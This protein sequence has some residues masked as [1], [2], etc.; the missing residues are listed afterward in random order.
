MQNKPKVSVVVV[1]YNT[2]DLLRQCLISVLKK[3]KDINYSTYV[4]DNGSTDDSVEMIKKEFST[5]NLILNEYNAGFAKANNQ[6]LSL[7]QS[8]YVLLLNSDTIFKSDVI[9]ELRNFMDKNNKVA[10][11]G[12]RLTR[13][14]GTIQ[15][16][17]YPI[18]NL[19]TAIIKTLR[20]Y[21]IL[22]RKTVGNIFL[23]SFWDHNKEKPVGRISGTC[24]LVRK[25]AMDEVGL[26]DENFFFYGEVHDWCWRMW[27]S[28]WEVWFSP[29]GDVV[30]LRGQT[31]KKKWNTVERHIIVLKET[32]RLFSKHLPPLKNWLII[33]NYFIS[34]IIGYFYKK[35]REKYSYTKEQELNILRTEIFWYAKWLFCGG[36]IK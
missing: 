7:V 4:V 31:A 10:I 28:N 19:G 30:H 26:L 15:P 32:F 6:A 20:L 5:V 8:E 34:D 24:I 1:N 22:P 14:N 29:L 11:V 18:P 9:S 27:K 36:Y 3:T 25:K 35:L 17:T 21:L 13:E 33:F 23:G 12:P 16:S 2:S